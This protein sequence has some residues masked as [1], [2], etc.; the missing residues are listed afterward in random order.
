MLLLFLTLSATAQR[1]PYFEKIRSFT[2]VQATELQLNEP[3]IIKLTNINQH[4]L[5][6]LYEAQT[7]AELTALY[8]V[9]AARL[10]AVFSKEQVTLLTTNLDKK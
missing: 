2:R 8:E 9:Y 3:D 4:T 10:N 7:E 5:P 6:L 1:S